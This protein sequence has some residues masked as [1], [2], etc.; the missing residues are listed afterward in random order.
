MPC[1]SCNSR[2]CVHNKDGG[3]I[4]DTIKVG[5]ESAQSSTETICESYVAEKGAVNCA[6]CG[7]EPDDRACENSG[8]DCSA[9][10]CMYNSSC[11]CTAENINIEKDG[12][13]HTFKK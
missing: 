12:T 9:E 8:I 7:C 1:I 13:C 3:C 5:G 6:S 2:D 11:E 10:E 4:L